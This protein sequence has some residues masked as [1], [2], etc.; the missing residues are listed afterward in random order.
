MSVKNEEEL[1][2]IMNRYGF[3][4][5]KPDNRKFKA[6]FFG[7]E[8][9]LTS[10]ELDAFTREIARTIGPN[11]HPIVEEVKEQDASNT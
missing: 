7:K 2:E 11:F 1:V 4:D 6:Y 5:P 10:S 9:I 3:K 8:A